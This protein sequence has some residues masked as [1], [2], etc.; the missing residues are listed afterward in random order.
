MYQNEPCLWNSTDPIYINVHYCSLFGAALSALPALLLT[1]SC[2]TWIYC[3]EY[4]NFCWKNATNI[5]KL[6]AC[7]AFVHTIHRIKISIEYLRI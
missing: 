2:L 5:M 7:D 6:L 3:I 4:V 1:D